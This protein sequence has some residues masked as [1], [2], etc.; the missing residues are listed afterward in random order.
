[1]PFLNYMDF[2]K[3]FILAVTFVMS[4]TS[5]RNFD[6]RCTFMFS[7]TLLFKIFWKFHLESCYCENKN[8]NKYLVGTKLGFYFQNISFH[9]GLT[10]I[11]QVTKL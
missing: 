2:F 10:K 9:E 5:V 4:E 11:I 8:Q 1:M 3:L 7:T 6:Q